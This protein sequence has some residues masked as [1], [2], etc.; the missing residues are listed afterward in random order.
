M[1][2]PRI[3]LQPT[4]QTTRVH[5]RNVARFEMGPEELL[6][7]MKALLLYL[8][9]EGERIALTGRGLDWARRLLDVRYRTVPGQVGRWHLERDWEERVKLFGIDPETMKVVDQNKFALIWSDLKRGER[10]SKHRQ[11]LRINCLEEGEPVVP[12]IEF[13][14]E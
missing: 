14:Q 7:A 10:V 2:R 13:V 8:P 6:E 5:T 9:E 12:L 4:Y 3:D 1:K 11:R